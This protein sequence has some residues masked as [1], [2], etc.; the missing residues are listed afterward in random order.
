[1]TTSIGTVTTLLRIV[2]RFATPWSATFAIGFVLT[3]LLMWNGHYHLAS[4][5][6]NAN[7]VDRL[8]S[9]RPGRRGR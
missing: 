8:I 3:T 6:I 7:L 1:M 2:L 4:N 9:K 5:A